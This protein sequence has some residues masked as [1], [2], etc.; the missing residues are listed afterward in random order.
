MGKGPENTDQHL[1]YIENK[2]MK[3]PLLIDESLMPRFYRDIPEPAQGWPDRSTPEN[4]LKALNKAH[5]AI[6]TL[7]GIQ[8]QAIAERERLKE[9]VRALWI[10]IITTLAALLTGIFLL[11]LDIFLRK[12]S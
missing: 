9:Q 3:D 4:Q 5:D 12:P 11:L 1:C 10:W 2:V 7:V 8:D 6:R